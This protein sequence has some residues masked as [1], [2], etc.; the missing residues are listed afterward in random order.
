MPRLIHIRS[1]VSE[2]NYD[3]CPSALYLP[4]CPFATQVTLLIGSMDTLKQFYKVSQSISEY[5]HNEILYYVSTMTQGSIYTAPS[6]LPKGIEKWDSKA[7][8]NAKYSLALE[9]LT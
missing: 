7:V 8:F 4:R 3:S 6:T 1:S 5:Q 9:V 2:W